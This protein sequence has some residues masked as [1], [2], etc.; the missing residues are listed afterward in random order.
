MKPSA[1]LINT[2]RGE[3]V[4]EPALLAALTGRRIAGAGLDSFAQE[5]PAA[6]NPLW[7]LDNVIVS[8]HCGG[9]TPEA[10]RE[11]SLMSVR[12]VMAF[13]NGEV[14]AQRLFVKG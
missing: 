5:P 12:N 11:V 14:L 8:S 9:G 1:F 10:R 2:A 3:V 6:D 7:G 13:L 4:E